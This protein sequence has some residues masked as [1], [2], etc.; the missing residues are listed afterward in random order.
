[1]RKRTLLTT[2]IAI[3]TGTAL[4]KNNE[5]RAKVG[6]KAREYYAK[7]M[8]RTADDTENERRTQIGHPDPHDYSDNKM[9]S[10]GAIYSV[11]HYDK[12]K[13]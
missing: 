5:N 1:M 9:V 10:E 7:L 12:N 11:K 8:N 3:G 6:R 4:L 13:Y 2:V